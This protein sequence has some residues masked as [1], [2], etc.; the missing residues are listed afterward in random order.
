M[1]RIGSCSNTCVTGSEFNQ[2]KHAC[3]CMDFKTKAQ[4]HLSAAGWLAGCMADWHNQLSRPRFHSLAT[5]FPRFRFWS[6]ESPGGTTAT[7]ITLLLFPIPSLSENSPKM[8]E[9][10]VVLIWP[11][12]KLSD[13]RDRAIDDVNP[14]HERRDQKR[15]VHFSWI[16]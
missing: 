14:E 12:T 13:V 1:F 3:Q 2:I 9:R 10:G 7:N 11:E 16:S 8:F 4:Q 15:Y 5:L 6:A